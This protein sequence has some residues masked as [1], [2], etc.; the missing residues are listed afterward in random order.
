VR[1]ERETESKNG[2]ERERASRDRLDEK[3]KVEKTRK[4][5]ERGREGGKMKREGERTNG[6]IGSGHSSDSLLDQAR[7]R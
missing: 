1:G 4:G 5:R 7:A 3:S 6:K 2:E